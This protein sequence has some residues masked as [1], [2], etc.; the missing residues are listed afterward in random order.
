M[1]RTRIQEFWITP[2]LNAVKDIL[3]SRYSGNRQGKNV[4][5]I[6]QADGMQAHI[7]IA[8]HASPSKQAAYLF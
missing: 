1:T 4:L 6:M 7:W 5:N 2:A 8:M 3:S